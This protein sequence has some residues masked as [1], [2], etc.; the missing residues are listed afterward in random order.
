[1]FRM[2]REKAEKSD[3]TPTVL[4]TLHWLSAIRCIQYK[5]SSFCFSRISGTFP[6]HLAE[7]LQLHIPTGQ[8]RSASDIRTFVIPL[9]NTKAF[10]ERS[11]LTL[12]RLFGQCLKQSVTTILF[13][14][15]KPSSRRTCSATLSKLFL[16]F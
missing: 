3:H 13:P 6:L 4:Q 10:G 9:A 1:M 15:L 16:S 11:F 12:A 5:M 7:Y 14:L 8:F 2:Q